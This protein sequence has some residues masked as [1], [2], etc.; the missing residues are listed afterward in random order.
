[1]TERKNNDFQFIDVGR[2]DPEKIA[3]EDRKQQFAEIYQSFEKVEVENQSHRCLECGNPYCEWKCPVH[4]YI[5]NW[6]KLVS[7][8]NIIEAAELSHQTNSLPEV[9]G[10]VCPQ[11]RLCEGACTL[12]D[13][14]GAVTIGATEKYITDTA[15]AMGW[16]PDMSKVKP[17]GKKVAIIGAG[18]AGI[19]CADILVRA[20]V[21]P[22]VYDRHPQIGG[23]L[24]FGIPE[25]KLEK[26]VMERRREVLEGMGVEFVLSTEV[27]KDVQMSE[28]IEEYDAVFLGMGTYK[29]MKGGFPGED[30]SG[31]YDAL[32]YLIANVNR[33]LGFEQSAE[34]FIGL[35]GQRVIVLG[36]GDT[37]M[38]CNRTAIRQGAA[39]VQCAYRR[40]EENMPGSRKEVQNAKEEGVEFL[41][42]RQPIEIV[43]DGKV[44]GIKVVS[45]ELGEADENGRRRPVV[46]E[47]SEEI[48]PADAVLVAFGFQPNPPTWLADFGVEINS[49]GGVIAEEQQACKFQTS[50]PKIFAG[51]DM[52]RG[53]DLVVTAIWEGRQAAEGILDYLEV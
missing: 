6:L 12:N 32:P 31:V 26:E 39:S 21:S 8:G 16:R 23:L 9:C 52:V 20:G 43:G 53:S 24:T 13:G 25:F 19:G 15:L 47:G 36:G 17:T 33:N 28:L 40:D 35:S 27:G 38:D 50:N 7:E 34:D 5:P 10:R 14:F 51:G 49:W 41:F 30:L 29:Y 22:V 11:D 46:I 42:N 37:A 4:N 3:A 44:E 2:Q 45:T 18:P 1:M 48:L